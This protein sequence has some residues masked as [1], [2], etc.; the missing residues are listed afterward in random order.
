[1][2]SYFPAFALARCAVAHEAVEVHADVGGFGGRIG[3]RDGAVERD[4]G[5]FVAAELHQERAAHAEEMEIIRQPRRQRLDHLERRFRPAHLGYRDRA[6]ERHHRR[7]L[8]HFQRA[9]EQID[10]GPVGVVGL[11]GARMQRRDRRLNL[12][13]PASPVPHRLVDQRQPLGDHLLIPQAAILVVEQDHR[14][15]SIEPRRR[16]GMLQQ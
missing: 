15:I 8:H 16:A 10:L 3:E 2:K 6:V 5:L 1:M 12:I 9:I 11:C 7:R 4:A 14:A 13:G